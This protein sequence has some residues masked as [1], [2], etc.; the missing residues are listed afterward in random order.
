MKQGGRVCPCTALHI[1]CCTWLQAGIL[2]PVGRS[3]VLAQSLPAVTSRRVWVC[4]LSQPSTPVHG[5]RRRPTLLPLPPAGRN[6]G[7][8]TVNVPQTRLKCA[9]ERGMCTCRLRCVWT[10]AL[11]VLRR[12][13]SNVIRLLPE[14]RPPRARTRVRQLL[15]VS[16]RAVLPGRRAAAAV[17]DQECGFCVVVEPLRL[18]N[19]TQVPA[20]H[21]A[22]HTAQRT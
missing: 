6:R 14:R 13:L 18:C 11:A 2:T 17:A 7:F 5:R 1:C 20:Q 10:P 8:H 15:F 19:L 16:T 3:V 4:W 21:T 12:S 22:R 9:H